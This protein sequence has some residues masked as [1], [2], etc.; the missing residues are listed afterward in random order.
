MAHGSEMGFDTTTETAMEILLN[1]CVEIFNSTETA[2][3]ICFRRFSSKRHCS[4]H[5]EQELKAAYAGA[6]DEGNGRLGVGRWTL[7]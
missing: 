5:R 7:D 3:E 4:R 2:T 1:A 6:D